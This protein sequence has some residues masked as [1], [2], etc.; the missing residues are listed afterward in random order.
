MKT[1]LDNIK[2][3]Y[4]P[5]PSEEEIKKNA[6]AYARTERR[7]RKKELTEIVTMWWVS[8]PPLRRL[9]LGRMTRR[10]KREAK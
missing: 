9:V 8:I 4:L 1:T 6:Q 7:K 5:L 2:L 10:L 3:D